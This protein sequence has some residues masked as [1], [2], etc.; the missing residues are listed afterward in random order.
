MLNGDT[1]SGTSPALRRAARP[2]LPEDALQFSP[3]GRNLCPARVLR[4]AVGPP[5]LPAQ[6]RCRP[7][8][9]PICSAG[10][11]LPGP[12]G[13]AGVGS[14]PAQ[15]HGNFAER[16]DSR[17][18]PPPLLAGVWEAPGRPLCR[19]TAPPPAPC[20]PITPPSRPTPSPAPPLPRP[21]A[22]APAR[23]AAPGRHAAGRR[24]TA[25]RRLRRAAAAPRSG[26][27]DTAASRRSPRRGPAPT[28]RS[29]AS[30]APRPPWPQPGAATA[31]SRRAPPPP[32]APQRPARALFT[33]RRPAP[34]RRSRPAHTRGAR[35][36][37]LRKAGRPS[38]EVPKVAERV[39]A[40]LERCRVHPS[41]P[42]LSREFPKAAE[43]RPSAAEQSLR[44][45]RPCGGAEG[46]A[47]RG[48]E[49]GAEVAVPA[50]VRVWSCSW[51]LAPR[52]GLRAD[53]D[54]WGCPSGLGEERGLPRA[55]V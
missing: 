34:P 36:P 17:R 38:R 51:P 21:A 32:P 31:L 24:G 11:R 41:A 28:P 30:A 49:C 6:S 10:T 9:Y 23:T 27:P 25:R 16:D 46:A 50:G 43:R 13:T 22:G 29:S 5:P 26:A 19:A 47:F 15:G 52:G 55:S 42:E 2:A 14:S 44:R 18:S 7:F 20:Q 33:A 1:A 8:P 53:A 35:R 37:R 12:T 39:R 4:M 40:A 54:G 3:A 45:R 48:G